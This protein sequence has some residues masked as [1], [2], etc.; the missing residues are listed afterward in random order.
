MDKKALW[1]NIKS[2]NFNHI[3]VPNAWEKIRES[4]GGTDACT[5]AFADKITRKH[6]WKKQ[7][8]LRAIAEYKKFVFLAVVSDFTV[9]PSKYIDVVWHEHLLFTKAYR[10]FCTEIID[11]NLDH[12]P[13]L[14]PMEAQTEKFKEQ[15]LNTLHNYIKEFGV[16]PP[17][18]IWEITKF[19]KE[20]IVDEL[21]ALKEKK[22]FVYSSFSPNTYTDS[23]PLYMSFNGEPNASSYPEFGGGDGGGGGASGDWGSDDGGSGSGDGGG[24]DGGGCSGGCGGGD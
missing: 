9:T 7:F 6:K 20:T 12:F 17:A 11:Y 13:E 8:C 10:D 3:A 2:Y 16:L 23:T 15:Y 4:F 1:L 5:A 18:A 19:D 14:I 22:K 21:N 24:G